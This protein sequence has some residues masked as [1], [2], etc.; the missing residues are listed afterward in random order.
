LLL[1]RYLLLKSEAQKLFG[2]HPEG[3]LSPECPPLSKDLMN[4]RCGDWPV[5]IYA[6]S[7]IEMVSQLIKYLQI[8]GILA[9]VRPV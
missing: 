6:N 8:S 3:F 7:V 9:Q 2:K 5:P 1:F 4:S